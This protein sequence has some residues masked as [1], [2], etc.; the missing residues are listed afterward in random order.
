MGVGLGVELGVG[1]TVAVALGVGDGLAVAVGVAVGIGVPVGLI[2]GV[3]VRLASG[4][5]VGVG[6]GS[7][8]ASETRYNFAPCQFTL[9]E[10]CPLNCPT[11][12]ACHKSR[13]WHGPLNPRSERFTVIEALLPV[14]LESR[15][16]NN[17]RYL[18]DALDSILAQTDQ[19]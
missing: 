14:P 13:I 15:V 4:V 18:A 1:N 5:D 12:L 3:G 11:S 16:L 19:T 8:V 6:L 7:N 17:A 2:V 9:A 10:N